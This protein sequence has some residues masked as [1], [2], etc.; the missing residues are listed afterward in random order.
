ME[1]TLILIKPDAI[2][3]GIAGTVLN[4]FERKGL[5]IVGIKMIQLTDELLNEHYSH[6][7][8][9]PFF[10]GIADFMKSTPVI[11]LAVEGLDC[12]E[13]VRR[14]CGVTKAREAQV[15]TI[16]GDLAM[17]IQ[18]N[19]VHAS[20]SLETAKKEVARFFN[21]SELFE[22][23]MVLYPNIYSSDELAS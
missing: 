5:K 11:A 1:R 2:Q 19:V 18:T 21:D 22:Y 17:S 6:I 9:K 8:D 23:D 15:G 7:A 4:R 13:T 3:R 14:L 12:V 20:D 16:R 10:K